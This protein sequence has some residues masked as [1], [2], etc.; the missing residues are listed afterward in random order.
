RSVTSA[1]ATCKW[2]TSVGRAD[3]GGRCNVQRL[4]I[5]ELAA[6]MPVS[7]TISEMK[8]L[9]P[10]PPPALNQRGHDAHISPAISSASRSQDRNLRPPE[11]PRSARDWREQIFVLQ[12]VEEEEVLVSYA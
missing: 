8:N 6:I 1:L 2:R 12:L 7:A 5:H 10:T 3:Q 4:P 9:C 11:N